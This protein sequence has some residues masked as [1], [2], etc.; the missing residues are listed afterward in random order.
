MSTGLNSQTKS[1]RVIRVLMVVENCPYSRDPRVRKEARALTDAGYRVSVICPRHG[2]GPT[3]PPQNVHV[4]EFPLWSS[5]KTGLGYL[6]EYSYGMMAIV[7]LS[8]W[9]LVREGFDIIHVANPPDCIIPVLSFYKLFGKPIIYDQHDLSPE[10]YAAKFGGNRWI[11]RLLLAI[12]R[13]SCLLADHIIV[14]N[15]SYKELSLQRCS[16][17]ESKITVVRNGPDLEMLEVPKINA[18]LRSKSRNIIAFA[19]VTGMQDGLDVLCRAL[20]YLRYELHADDFYCIVLGDG[21]ALDA[22]KRLAE[23]VG[24]A[25]RIQFA[26]WVDDPALYSSYIATADICVAPEPFNNYNDRSTFV[27]IMEYMSAGKPIVAFDLRE[28]RRSAEGAA[29][30]ARVNDVK[31]FAQK[32]ATF[33]A[34]PELRESTGRIGRQR[35]GQEL[36]WDY[37]TPGLLSAYQRVASQ[38]SKS[39]TPVHPL[40]GDAFRKR[41]SL[42]ADKK[43]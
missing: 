30:Y 8:L 4:Y 37:S 35:I 34:R 43:A 3:K 7:L 17:P 18:E 26:G 42:A 29:L 36:A 22:T 12:E 39:T 9:V 16:T 15:E 20:H 38:F 28:T 23:E 14:T 31:D 24:I 11:C 25:D 13:Y 41:V 10:L 6:V 2:T 27:K 21:D 1:E 5:T 33:I 40:I 32:I 19:G